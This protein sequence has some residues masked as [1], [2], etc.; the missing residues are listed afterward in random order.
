MDPVRK[1]S[2]LQTWFME[3]SDRVKQSA[4]RN[5]EKNPNQSVKFYHLLW[6]GKFVMSN[7]NS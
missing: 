3:E 2:Q 5:W 4:E 7:T 6:K 1:Q